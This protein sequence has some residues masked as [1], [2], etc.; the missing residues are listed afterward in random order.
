MSEPARRHRL[1]GLEPDNL[2]A[3]L[4]LLGLLRALEHRHPEWRPRAYWDIDRPPLRPVLML[5]EPCEKRAIAEAAAK[6]IARLADL[7]TFP[8]ESQGAA[9]TDL[10]YSDRFARCLLKKIAG[11]Q[12]R[13]AADLWAAL[14]CDQAARDGRIEA[15]PM[16]LLFGQGHQHFLARLSE[17]PRMAA[18]PLRGRGKNVIELSADDTIEQAVFQPWRRE[19]PTPGFRWDPAED[20]RYALRAN[21]PSDEKSTTQHGANRLAVLGLP[22]FTVTP[23]Q[24]GDRVRLRVVGA[25]FGRDFT[26]AWPIWRDPASL[27]AIRALLSH[28]D[29]ASGKLDDLAHLGVIQIRRADRIGVGKFMNFTR[30]DVV[31]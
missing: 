26:V 15:T 30:A 1:D 5:S 4:A 27:A 19:D 16:C 23:E 3:F 11:Q 18:P 28:P 21:N 25:R 10:N 20:V 13:D 7:Y 24:R 14:M 17:V 9:Q 6:G 29:L 22:V 12:N 8:A 31:G 2:L